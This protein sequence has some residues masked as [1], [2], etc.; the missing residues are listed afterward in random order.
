MSAGRARVIDIVFNLYTP[1]E[2]AI[3]G[4]SVGGAFLDRVRVGS[5]LQQGL[6][7]EE[8]VAIMDE[9]GV[10]VALLPAIKAGD[11]RLRD[12]WAI[13]YRRVAEVCE[14][15]PD[16]F[17]GLAGVDP[18]L[19]MAGLRELELGVRE[20][21]FVG[22]HLYP[23]WF[24][25]APD[26][27]RY[28]PIYA[29]CCELDVPIMMQVGHCLS[30]GTSRTHPNVGRPQ[31][32]DVVACDFPELKLIGIHLG[33]P[34]TDEMI[35]V[36]YKHA[37]VFIGSDAYA[38]RH[39][40]AEFRRFADSWGQDKVLFGTD[41]PIIDPRRARREIAELGLRPEPLGKLLG[42]NA[43]RLFRLGDAG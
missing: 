37:N 31:A 36:A 20:H 14:Q 15:H 5:R 6:S 42:L 25:M 34:W 40:P 32:L 3:R 24:E 11:T 16:R 30:Y 13:P 26:H 28:Y 22:A 4:S 7:V 39:W 29:K 19:G 35:S 12:S 43:E 9:A 41:F 17:R 33:Y 10:D 38:P 23:H 1:N 18:T 2:V 21:G 27:A 8:Q